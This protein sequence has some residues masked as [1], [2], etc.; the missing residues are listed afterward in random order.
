M[1]GP[2]V[3]ELWRG[4]VLNDGSGSVDTFTGIENLIGGSNADTLSGD[5]QANRLEGSAGNDTLN[6]RRRRRYPGSA[7]SAPIP[8]TAAAAATPSTTAP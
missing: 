1:S 5:F 7:D 6:G 2:V 4:S 3:A 8:S